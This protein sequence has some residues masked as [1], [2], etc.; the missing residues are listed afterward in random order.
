MDITNRRCGLQRAPRRRALTRMS[1]PLLARGRRQAHRRSPGRAFKLRRAAVPFTFGFLGSAVASPPPLCPRLGSSSSSSSSE[2]PCASRRGNSARLLAARSR[3]P[4]ARRRARARAPSSTRCR[5]RTR[6][7]RRPSAARARAARSAGAST[8]C[9]SHLAVLVVGLAVAHDDERRAARRRAALAADAQ[10]AHGLARDRRGVAHADG[11]AR[12]RRVDRALVEHAGPSGAARCRPA[13]ARPPRRTAR[14]R[15]RTSPARRGARGRT[16]PRSRPRRARPRSRRPAA[17]A[18][19]GSP[20]SR[21]RAPRT[22]RREAAS[23]GLSASNPQYHAK[24]LIAPP[25][26]R[27]FQ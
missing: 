19:A 22:R 27:E 3:V 1:K 17:R 5:H 13:A 20:R 23:S 21:S 7:R 8:S 12:E 25:L 4:R 16:P 24:L 14:A 11:R 15:G 6:A 9:T 2:S 18:R 10:H 26:Y